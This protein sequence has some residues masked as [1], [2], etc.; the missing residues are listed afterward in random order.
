MHMCVQQVESSWARSEALNC[1]RCYFTMTLFSDKNWNSTENW[2]WCNGRNIA[3][4]VPPYSMTH[5]ENVHPAKYA[6]HIMSSIDF[7]G[8]ETFHAIFYRKM[9]NAWKIK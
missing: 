4:G 8:V 6:W 7:N 2:L 3:F 5:M 9:K 1:Y